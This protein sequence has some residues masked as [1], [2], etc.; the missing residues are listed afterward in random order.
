MCWCGESLTLRYS[1]GA[2]VGRFMVAEQDASTTAATTMS[3][4]AD[5]WRRAAAAGRV[6]AE[7]VAEAD[8]D[9]RELL[10]HLL[11]MTA[12]GWSVLVDRRWPGTGHE[13]AIVIGAPGI[14]V[15]DGP[16]D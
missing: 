3:T 4:V 10:A 15:V 1:V 12:F 14:F 16:A 2:F 9:Q 6:R 7:S 8:P 11:T 5:E 13:T